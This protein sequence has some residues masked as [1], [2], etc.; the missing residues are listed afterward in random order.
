MTMCVCIYIY[1]G[2]ITLGV[3]IYIYMNISHYIHEYCCSDC[4]TDAV[5]ILED[6]QYISSLVDEHRVS[7]ALFVPSLLAEPWQLWS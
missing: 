3:Y 7:H 2:R 5:R 1:M 6:F 4:R